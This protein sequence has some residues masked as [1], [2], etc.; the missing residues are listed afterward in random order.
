MNLAPNYD[1]T[2]TP[3]VVTKGAFVAE[4]EWRQRFKRGKV[5]FHLIAASLNDDFKS[6][7][8]NIN[9]DWNAIISSPFNDPKDLDA[10]NKK[11][12]FDY[13]DNTHS[14]IN[15]EVADK[16]DTRPSSIADAIGYDFRGSFAASGNFE[17]DNWNLDFS[18]KFVS[19]DTF[20]RRFDL[21]DETEIK[22]YLSIVKKLEE[23]TTRNKFNLLFISSS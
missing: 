7:T 13:D 21:D 16:N 15:V 17:L 12:V 23:C 18:G 6:K 2:I 5:N 22:S 1:L 20:L 10:V 14:I 11:L 3:W 4:G 9:D 8:V 19:D